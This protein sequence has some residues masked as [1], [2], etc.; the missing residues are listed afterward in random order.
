[1][2]KFNR[3]LRGYD[4][5]EVNNFLDKVIK[6]VEIMVGELNEKDEKIARLESLNDENEALREKL[7]QYRRTE[8]TMN[9]AIMMAQ[10]TGDQMRLQA[11]REGD[12][13]IDNAK[14]NANRI[15]NDALLRAEKTEYE[16]NTLRRNI[17]LFKR[18]LKGIIETQLEMVE[19]IDQVEL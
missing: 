2:E 9:K 11:A 16:A 19:E 10:K 15:V 7:D 17:V 6:Q 4:P 12:L 1:M 3:T 8:E 5:T 18:R 14:K 13:I